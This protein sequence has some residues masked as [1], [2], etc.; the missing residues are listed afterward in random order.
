VLVRAGM[1]GVRSG[2]GSSQSRDYES[3]QCW[4]VMEWE[5]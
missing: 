3:I 1:S 2:C 4:T 5:R